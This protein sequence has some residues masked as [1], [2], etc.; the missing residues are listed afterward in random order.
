MATYTERAPQLNVAISQYHAGQIVIPV[1][2]ATLAGRGTA[3]VKLYWL[4]QSDGEHL[5]P[6]TFRGSIRDAEDWLENQGVVLDAQDI[7]VV[8]VR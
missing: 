1:I 6:A 2:H 3:N 8:R 7:Y 5:R 4:D